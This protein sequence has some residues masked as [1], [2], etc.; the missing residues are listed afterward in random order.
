MR[1]DV[2]INIPPGYDRPHFEVYIGRSDGSPVQIATIDR[3]RVAVFSEEKVYE[4]ECNWS[5]CGS[6]KLPFLAKFEKAITHCRIICEKLEGVAKYH[7][8]WSVERIVEDVR[9]YIEWNNLAVKEG[10]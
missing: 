5:A 4:V 2:L 3:R 1:E 9:G 6:Q 10:D 8:D 7:P